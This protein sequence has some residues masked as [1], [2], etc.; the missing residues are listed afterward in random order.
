MNI[1]PPVVGSHYLYDAT[2][3]SQGVSLRWAD[4]IYFLAA[5]STSQEARNEYENCHIASLEHRKAQG[6]KQHEFVVAEVIDART[7]VVVHAYFE[8]TTSSETLQL[9][10][11]SRTVRISSPRLHE[12]TQPE[13]ID[14]I[15]VNLPRDG[16]PV[17]PD[18]QHTKPVRGKIFFHPQQF[19]IVDL[20]VIHTVIHR[21]RP[22]YRI[23]ENQCY[24]Y[25][26]VLYAAVHALHLNHSNIDGSIVPG[27][28]SSPVTEEP[29]SGGGT[30]LYL[31]I[32]QDGHVPIDV[33][34]REAQAIRQEL[35]KVRG[36]SLPLM[37]LRSRSCSI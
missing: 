5:I 1:M 8:R 3:Q 12:G 30:Y 6:D 15:T 26:N 14:L 10:R 23:D 21:H 16:E 24:W 25:A 34:R 7:K 20:A 2:L 37:L 9:V 4:P 29:F 32:P 27:A 19:T 33:L 35:G 36:F 13:A 31:P 17:H 22:V 28:I 11:T 18:Y